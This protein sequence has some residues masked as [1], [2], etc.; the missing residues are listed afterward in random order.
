MNEIFLKYDFSKKNSPL[1]YN[2]KSFICPYDYWK[3]NYTIETELTYAITTIEN[4]FE[5]T[6]SLVGMW[7]LAYGEEF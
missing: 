1:F 7:F 2:L 6:S 3:K 5:V 4:A